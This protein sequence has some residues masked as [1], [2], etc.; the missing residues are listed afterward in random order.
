MDIKKI[1]CIKNLLT[2]F[3]SLLFSFLILELISRQFFYEGYLPKDLYKEDL[4]LGYS[5]I[6]NSIVEYGKGQYVKINSIGLR[7]RDSIINYKEH[8]RT[9]IAFLGDC[10]CN[11]LGYKDKST[12]GF[13]LHPSDNRSRN[14]CLTYLVF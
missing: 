5:H 3:L 1:N 13:F 6:P 8:N 4:E 14:F 12:L 7:S 11:R 9:R 10:L 2:L